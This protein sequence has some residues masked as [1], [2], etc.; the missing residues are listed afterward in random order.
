VLEKNEEKEILHLFPGR[1]V[2]ILAARVVVL[3]VV[4]SS[5]CGA[6][7]GPRAA[8]GMVPCESAHNAPRCPAAHFDQPRGALPVR[9][10]PLGV[11]VRKFG[12]RTSADS[13]AGFA[14][15]AIRCARLA[16]DTVVH[17][18]L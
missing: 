12:D 3:H 16:F 1:H 8:L 11:G 5:I 15:V 13:V 10:V 18:S 7:S 6:H 4:K 9:D 17:P 14:I 2:Q